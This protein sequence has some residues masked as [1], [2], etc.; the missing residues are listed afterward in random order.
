MAEAVETTAQSEVRIETRS[1]ILASAAT[2][3]ALALF[4]EFTDAPLVSSAFALIILAVCALAWAV[5]SLN[6]RAGTWFFVA[7]LTALA[8]FAI[9]WLQVD[10]AA[11]LLPIPGGLAMAL[12]GW[13]AGTLVALIESGLIVFA[14]HLL[15]DLD[16]TPTAFVL[17]AIWATL[18]TLG[19]VYHKIVHLERWLLTSYDNLQTLLAEVR[20]Q[21]AELEQTKDNWAHAVRQ[22]A[23]ANER[24]GA[25][26]LVAEQARKAKADF[27][28]KVSHEFRTP[29]NIIVGMVNLMAENPAI[30]GGAFPPR[31]QEHLEIVHRNCQHLASLVDDVL[32]L[33]QAEAGCLVMH[34]DWI[35]LMDVIETARVVVQPLVQEKGLTLRISGPTDLPQVYCDRVRVRQVV[36]NLLSNAARF[37]EQGSIAVT[38]RRH[39]AHVVISVT[40]TGPGISPDDAERIFEPF[41][42]VSGDL[43]PEK[44]GTGLGLSIS[45]QFVELHGGRMWLETELGA[46]TTF[47]LELPI[48]PPP[49]H[50][51]RS[52]HQI[53]EHWPWMERASWTDLSGLVAKPRIVICSETH[54]L[55][56]EMA[57]GSDEIE[58]I[59]TQELAQALREL[60]RCPAHALVI[61]DD[62]PNA[63]LELVKRASHT[64]PSTP[65]IGCC[66]HPRLADIEAAG[67]VNYLTKP[68]TCPTL[69]AAIRT[70]GAPVRRVLVVDD[71]ADARELLTLMVR[72]LNGA[73]EVKAVASG[74]EALAE[75]RAH[76][77]DLLLLDVLMPDMDGWQ[78]LALMNA[79]ERIR[80]IPVLMVS[81]QDLQEG[82]PTSD[83]LVATIGEGLPLSKL[84]DYSRAFSTLMLQAD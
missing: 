59:D 15:G 7:G 1:A 13:Q 31:A 34:R 39:D 44:R 14:P 81:A 21:K 52:G 3:V 19:G 27:V 77:W 37:T 6:G 40:D 8:F 25:L 76:P 36:L 12:I 5:S 10:L 57:R 17:I 68:V 51:A 53:M 80:E 42:R 46:G 82:P 73:S 54:D 26:R 69:S 62:S 55:H 22:L 38:V 75:L 66:Y 32:A 58:L 71:E 41:T 47:F 48:A 33:S 50:T 20:D 56:A 35:D 28:A 11:A 60:E 18:A 9:D 45:R 16:P 79:D 29:L 49:P 74:E 84:A 61:S 72:T 64:S 43:V 30:Y 24:L 65:V 63:L 23:L 4:F 83:M 2:A 70:L 67:A 78:M